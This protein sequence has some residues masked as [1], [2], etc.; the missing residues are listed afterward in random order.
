MTK[1]SLM[2]KVSS[3]TKLTILATEVIP[4]FNAVKWQ[5]RTV[6]KITVQTVGGTIKANINES[7][8]LHIEVAIM[9]ATATM[10]GIYMQYPQHRK[11]VHNNIQ[12]HF[13]SSEPKTLSL[14]LASETL[15]QAPHR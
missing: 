3:L 13:L 4:P 9:A 1:L 12:I 10:A 2:T 8:A 6:T 15:W 14:T 5:A 11:E 7:G